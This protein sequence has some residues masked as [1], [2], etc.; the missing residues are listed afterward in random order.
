[1]GWRELLGGGGGQMG[2]PRKKW[3]EVVIKNLRESKI[4]DGG[5]KRGIERYKTK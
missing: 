4:I 5:I 3:S 1:M 2:R